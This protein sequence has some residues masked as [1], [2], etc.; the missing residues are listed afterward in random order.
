LAQ[1]YREKAEEG[2]ILAGLAKVFTNNA[3]KKFKWK[4]I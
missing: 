1:I 4:S 3:V 2:R